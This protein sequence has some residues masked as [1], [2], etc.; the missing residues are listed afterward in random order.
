M[1]DKIRRLKQMLT[2]KGSNAL[3]QV[4]G[5]VGAGNEKVDGAVVDNLQDLFAHTG[6]QTVIDT[7]NGEHGDEGGAVDGA[8]EDTE[9]V[10]V[11]GCTDH[12]AQQHHHTQSAA[13]NVGNHIHQF[14]PT[15]ISGENPCM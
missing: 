2:E 7:G 5:G 14:F 1:M 4:D 9:E 15:G 11:E 3:I 6:G 13:Y 10:V 8:A 12:T